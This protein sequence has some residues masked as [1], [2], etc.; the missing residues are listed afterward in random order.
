MCKKKTTF[1]SMP[2]PLPFLNWIKKIEEK[3]LLVFRLKILISLKVYLYSIIYI[4]IHFITQNRSYN[5]WYQ[6]IIL[7]EWAILSVSMIHPFI[8]CISIDQNLFQIIPIV[9]KQMMPLLLVPPS[10]LRLELLIVLVILQPK[11]V[12]HLR[13]AR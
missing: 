9:R 1:K 5:Y 8:P 10:Q 4:T 2:S 3:S 11:Q 6:P 13:Q 12:K 7:M